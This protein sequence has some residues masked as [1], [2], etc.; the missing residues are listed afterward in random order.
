MFCFVIGGRRNGV[1]MQDILS[2]A[3][4]AGEETVLGFVL[5]PKLEFVEYTNSFLPT[6]ST[7]T[8]SLRLPHP[9]G[10]MVIP[11]QEKLFDLYDYA[12]CNA[13]FG[14]I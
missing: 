11:P 5:Q 7:C 3:T 13:Y 4:G 6:S 14:V 8:N 10:S 9:T 2:F 12:F 1:Q